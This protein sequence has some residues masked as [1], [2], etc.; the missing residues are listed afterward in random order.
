[1]RF[2]IV[3]SVFVLFACTIKKVGREQPGSPFPKAVE[4][5]H[6]MTF[7]ST[8]YIGPVSYL[9]DTKEFYTP[10]Y[11]SEDVKIDEAYD[12][13]TKSVDSLLYAED[14]LSRKRLPYKTAQWF[15]KLEGMSTISLFN[16]EHRKIGEAKLVRLELHTDKN[17]DQ[18][19]AA[20][21]PI[22]PL[23]YTTAAVYCASASQ[24]NLSTVKIKYEQVR[25][26]RITKMIFDKFGVNKGT[27]IKHANLRIYNSMYST[28][29][30]DS[31]CLLLEI[32]NGQVEV[33]HQSKEDY[34]ITQVLPTHFEINGKPVLIASMN[35][36]DSDVIWTSLAVFTGRR[37]EFAERCRVTTK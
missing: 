19:I 27:R 18:F 25:N 26:E 14:G 24:T 10:L 35:V 23:K 4:A 37:Y 11:Y 5:S 7:D 30:L 2:A 12:F 28:L 22:A 9:K 8:V 15:F 20:Y 21:E 6:A 1:M 29:D 34:C 17:G 33:V 13:L 31:A 3:L 16:T 36:R 32:R